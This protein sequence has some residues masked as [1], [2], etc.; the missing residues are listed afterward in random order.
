F[1]QYSGYL[2]GRFDVSLGFNHNIKYYTILLFLIYYI[3]NLKP[4]HQ[5]NTNK[6]I[7]NGL[8]FYILIYGLSFNFA[9]LYRVAVFFQTFEI[10]FLVYYSN[11]L[12]VLP[13]IFSKRLV[14]LLFIGIFTFS[15]L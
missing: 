12:E 10:I 6:M 15:S 14:T 2:G 9:L 1:V 11:K 4:F 3:Y 7:V 5:N 8:L 13:E